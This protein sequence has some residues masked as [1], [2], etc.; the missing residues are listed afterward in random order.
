[1]GNKTDLRKRLGDI[2]DTLRREGW[3]IVFRRN[4]HLKAV[5]PEGKVVFMSRT[6]SDWR[7]LYKI[8]RDLKANG[9]TFL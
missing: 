1:V 2:L 8:K 9:A 3:R 6:P 7:A 4:G 5:S